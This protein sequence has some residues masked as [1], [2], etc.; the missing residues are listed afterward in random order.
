[1]EETAR[2]DAAQPLER[3]VLLACALG[4]FALSLLLRLLGIGWGLPNEFRH[5][6]LHPDELIIAGHAVLKPYFLPDFYNYG[7]TYLTLLKLGTDA[8]TAYGWIPTGEN[9][10]EWQTL[11]AVHLTGRVISAFCGA[12]TVLLVFL[13]CLQFTNILGALL[14]S[15]ALTVAPGHLVHSQFQTTD[16]LSTLLAAAALFAMVRWLKRED[17]APKGAF[18][19]A[20]WVGLFAGTRYSG[21]VLILLAIGLVLWRCKRERLFQMALATLGGAAVGFV[22]ATPG[23]ILQ[24]S[25]FVR[26]FLYESG[27]V[28]TGH[29][30]VFAETPTGFL[31]HL[32]N[33]FE[34]FGWIQTLA[35]AFGLLLLARTRSLAAYSIVGYALLYYLLI[36]SAEVK[37]L[38]YT[39]P[40]LPALCVGVAILAGTFHERDKW[41]KAMP[42]A[43]MLAIGLNVVS[44]GGAVSLLHFMRIQDPRDR[45]AEYVRQVR[46]PGET[47]GFVTTPWF[48][49]PP[50]FPDT[51]LPGENERLE[52]MKQYDPTLVVHVRDGKVV[53]W[54]VGLL[55]QERPTYIC[56]STFEYIDYRRIQEPHFVS[57]LEQLPEDYELIAWAWGGTLQEDSPPAATREALDSLFLG[58]GSDRRYPLTHD[59]MYIQ[60]TVCVLKR[61]AN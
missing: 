41:S 56:I 5:Q 7:T 14:A 15:L 9:V 18:L 38:R 25:S 43:I 50:L 21:I 28:R 55:Q 27:H 24:T 13:L 61:K 17:P 1:M 31:Y 33:L 2:E 29:G 36:G 35:A 23:L 26:D 44:P 59:M 39:L 46:Q 22:V 48:Y 20:L 12:L 54:D 10:P 30:I 19:M 52:R 8:G 57:F 16:A 45:I 49:T 40:L 4:L 6:S 58:S 32:G 47:V 53:P 42:A 34:G 3:R 51:G 37:F 11:G 60:P